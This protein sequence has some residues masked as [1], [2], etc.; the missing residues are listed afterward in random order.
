MKVDKSGDCWMWTAANG[1]F[2]YGASWV[3]GKM[4][5]SHRISYMLCIGPI[6]TFMCILHKCDN[7]P[8]VNP[9]HLFLGTRADNIA[10]MKAKGRSAYGENH[11]RAKLTEA[12]IINIRSLE[13]M[14]KRQSDLARKWGISTSHIS[15]IVNR[16]IWR[17]VL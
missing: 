2:G 16:K 8:C 17:H 4:H 7:P 15:Y 9:E 13:K 5:T 11:G 6:P 1:R 14:G 3:N 10:D 12:D